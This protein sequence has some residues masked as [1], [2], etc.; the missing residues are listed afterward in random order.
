MSSLRVDF[1]I[2]TIFSSI[3]ICVSSSSNKIINHRY[4]DQSLD[5]KEGKIVGWHTD[6]GS[7]SQHWEFIS[8][9]GGKLVKIKNVASSEYLRVDG[10]GVVTGADPY[11]WQNVFIRSGRYQ[12][13]T[14]NGSNILSLTGGS[15]GSPVVLEESNY[16]W[17]D[18]QWRYEP[19]S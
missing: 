3:L 1:L 4:R 2:Y 10:Q 15:D 19:I 6:Y 17:E 16:K 12:L 9:D 18:A 11:E 7:K 14:T 13:A 5:V 8:E